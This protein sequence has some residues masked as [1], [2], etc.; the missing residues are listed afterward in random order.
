MDGYDSDDDIERQM[1]LEYHS[2]VAEFSCQ[3][4]D[5]KKGTDP[6]ASD[7]LNQ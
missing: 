7:N 2:N 6:N 3:L 5:D 1:N 4:D